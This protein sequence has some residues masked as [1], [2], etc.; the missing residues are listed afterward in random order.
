MISPPDLISVNGVKLRNAKIIP[1]N[2]KNNPMKIRAL[3]EMSVKSSSDISSD[4]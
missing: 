3:F 1:K 4:P 2:I